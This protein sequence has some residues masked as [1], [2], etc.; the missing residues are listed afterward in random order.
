MVSEI[1]A[2]LLVIIFL[3]L[4]FVLG[5]R[6]REATKVLEDIERLIHKVN[7]ALEDKE[8]TYEEAKEIAEEIV[9]II[10]EFKRTR[11]E[12]RR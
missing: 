2:W 9:R 11:Q 6:L 3:A 10:N 12:V 8:L 4:S 7:K 1:V 5:E